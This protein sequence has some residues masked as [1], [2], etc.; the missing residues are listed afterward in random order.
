MNFFDDLVSKIEKGVAETGLASRRMMDLGKLNFK[1]KEK[2]QE[3]D[4]IAAKIGWAIYRNWE[5]KKTTS[6]DGSLLNLIEMLETLHQQIKEL[7]LELANIKNGNKMKMP[8]VPMNL[9]LPKSPTLL[10]Y[11]CPYCA[12]QVS[13]DD[14]QCKNC[15]KRYY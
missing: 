15:Q 8:S 2:K 4:E 14:R 3:A 6:M 10:V 13:E 5:N 9:S 1:V 12:H 7:E 11:L